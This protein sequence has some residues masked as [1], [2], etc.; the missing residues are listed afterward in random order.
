MATAIR[1]LSSAA[2]LTI[3][4]PFQIETLRPKSTIKKKTQVDAVFGPG[5]ANGD[6]FTQSVSPQLHAALASGRSACVLSLGAEQSG[7]TTSMRSEDGLAL[8]AVKEVFAAL[9]TTGAAESLVSVSA[10]CCA[11]VP[12]QGNTPFTGKQPVREVLID[13]LG[14]AKQPAAGL[15]VREH[16]DGLPHAGSPF[17]A[18]GLREAPATSAAEA[19]ALVRAAIA[20]CAEEEAGSALRVHLLISLTVRQRDGAAERAFTI[21]LVDV[22]GVPRP[23]SGAAARG[24]AGRGAAASGGRGGGSNAGGSGEDPFVKAMYRILDT[25]QDMKPN[26]MGHVPYRDAKL[27]RLI[28]YGLGGGGLS[29]PI[30]HIRAD[31]FEE[32]EAVLTLC[33]KLP[34]L[35]SSGGATY[36][37]TKPIITT[38]KDGWWSPA[39]EWHKAEERA[40]SLAASLGLERKGLVSRGI[41]LDHTSSDELLALQ[42]TLLLAERLQYRMQLWEKYH[43]PEYTSSHHVEVVSEEPIVARGAPAAAALRELPPQEAEPF[44]PSRLRLLKQGQQSGKTLGGGFGKAALKRFE[45]TPGAVCEAQYSNGCFYKARITATSRADDGSQLYVVR[46]EDDGITAHLPAEKLRRAVDVLKVHA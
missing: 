2:N 33:P 44:D 24:G 36:T 1:V 8:L 20:R 46:F 34:K 40:T 10:V 18:E 32:A 26:G 25:L 39:D 13:A 5:I 12:A 37:P 23:T 3:T 38:G 45:P 17:F 7:K 30:V 43:D 31:R 29:I 4:S 9:P 41:Q 14:P 42:E 11:I 19:E 35:T 21:S 15:T 27:T 16:A 6:V 28:S 22:A